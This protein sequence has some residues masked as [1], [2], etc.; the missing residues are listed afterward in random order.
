MK[1]N[2]ANKIAKLIGQI[3]AALF[4][5]F[6]LLK[7][8]YVIDWSWWWVFSPLWIFAGIIVLWFI[9]VAVIINVH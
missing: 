4:T 8:L 3:D 1:N 2:K 9:F 6:F 7:C 5:T